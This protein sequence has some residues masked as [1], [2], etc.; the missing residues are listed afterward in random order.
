MNDLK[1]QLR[2]E[3]KIGHKCMGRIFRGTLFLNRAS[4]EALKAEFG[5][6]KFVD[7]YCDDDLKRIALKPGSTTSKAELKPHSSGRLYFS[8]RGFDKLYG[9]GPRKYKMTE[10]G[11]FELIEGS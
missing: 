7:L 10:P 6:L 2:N 3:D 4:V 5:E 9:V 1:L 11:V 8:L